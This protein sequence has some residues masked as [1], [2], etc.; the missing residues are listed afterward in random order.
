MAFQEYVCRE[1]NMSIDRA[2]VF[3]Q[4]PP[5]YKLISDGEDIFERID[6]SHLG[7]S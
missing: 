4:A 7:L 1:R 6:N 2:W 5:I 3:Q